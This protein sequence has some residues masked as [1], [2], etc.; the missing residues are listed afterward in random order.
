MRHTKLDVCGTR[1]ESVT[2]RIPPKIGVG[3][4]SDSWNI[5]IY[6]PHIHTYIFCRS[7]ACCSLS[8]AP[9]N[10]KYVVDAHLCLFGGSN[11]C[12]YTFHSVD[13]CV[14]VLLGV[15]MANDPPGK[16]FLSNGHRNTQAQAQAQAEGIL[17][18]DSTRVSLSQSIDLL[19]FW[20]G[21]KWK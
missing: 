8:D 1:S 12:R 13:G 16:A 20:E 10:R 3:P 11:S 14:C 2:R 9:H 17:N 6:Q 18:L 5:H 15:N 7:L 19:N 4:G 21:P